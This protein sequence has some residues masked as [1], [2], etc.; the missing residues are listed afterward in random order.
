MGYTFKTV[1]DAIV[2]SDGVISFCHHVA[3]GSVV[4]LALYPF[5]HPHGA[6][7]V[8]LSEV[9]TVALCVVQMFM[10]DKGVGLLKER[11]P[12]FDLFMGLLFTLLFIVC[13]IMLWGFYSFYFWKDCLEILMDGTAHSVPAVIWYL[14]ANFCLSLL[15][16]F[17]LFEIFK[18]IAAIFGGDEKKKK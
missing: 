7:F 2:Y 3:T 11:F 5:L 8:G 13:R 6:F 14:F 12:T 10:K 4:A 17:W 9:S 18:G 16:I 1:G 15:Q